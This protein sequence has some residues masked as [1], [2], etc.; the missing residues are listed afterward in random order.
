MTAGLFASFMAAA[1]IVAHSHADMELICAVIQF[2]LA[3][4]FLALW[5]AAPDYKVFAGMSFYLALFSL[6]LSLFYF[7]D[8][9]EA[10]PLLVAITAPVVV[11]IAAEAMRI[12]KRRWTWIVWPICFAALFSGWNPH[13]AFLRD[14]PI[15][16]TQVVLGVLIV[17]GFRSKSARDRQIAAA[18]LLLFCTRWTV[19]PEFRA[20]T[21]V[22]VMIETGRF[23][24][25]ISPLSTIVLGAATLVI[26]VRDLVRD[27]RE[28]QRMALE[29]E[30]A[31]AVQQVL[32]PDRQ[33]SSPGI[34]IQSVYKPFG[35][36]GGDFFQILP[37]E[38][39]G[40]MVV[41]G[42]VSGKGLPA[43][44]MVALLV[45][46]L[47][48]LAERTSRPAEMLAGLN[49]RVLG[50]SGGGFTTCLVTRIDPG[51]ELTLAS[52]G[53]LPP[54]LDGCAV[55]LECGLPLG[56]AAGVEYSEKRL[57]LE[58][59]QRLTLI[60]DGVLEARDPAGALFGFERTAAISAQTADQIAKAAERFGQ[61][62]DITV[63]T[64]V[65]SL[66]V[67]NE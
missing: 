15:N 6:N 5:I 39:G 35:E 14:W 33:P 2:C 50:R 11:V 59:G 44:M 63:L 46:T 54:Y 8:D 3:A 58:P 24:W 47:N 51:G 31:R 61:D 40:V 57:R 38:D 36:V 18:F 42:D 37:M 1:P 21:H 19:S 9:R 25:P 28:K 45:G 53:H 43:A 65:R 32:I 17:Q 66:Q 26:F 64:V 52:A 67:V 41:I 27:R 12:T 4:A 23:N 49:R 60:T 29:L 30:A 13:L 20:L 10:N 22:P 55:E 34:S 56:I 16:V 48:T 7:R 62:D